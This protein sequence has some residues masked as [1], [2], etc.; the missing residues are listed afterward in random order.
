M[1]KDLSHNNLK[2]LP[3]GIGFMVRL[4]ELTASHNSL[5]YIPDDLTMLSSN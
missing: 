2:G 4:K 3:N 1:I 5:Q